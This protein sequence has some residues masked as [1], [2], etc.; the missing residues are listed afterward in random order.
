MV[1]TSK[2]QA[3]DAEGFLDRDQIAR[4]GI[5][6]EAA[7]PLAEGALVADVG[8]IQVTTET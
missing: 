1:E 5:K 6:T 2:V 8:I 3:P 7:V 4:N